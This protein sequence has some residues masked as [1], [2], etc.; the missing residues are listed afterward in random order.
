M[1]LVV[2]F[3]RVKADRVG[4]ALIRRRLAHAGRRIVRVSRYSPARYLSQQ[5][6]RGKNGAERDAVGDA[7]A[8]PT[9]PLILR[10]FERLRVAR[11]DRYALAREPLRASA[12]RILIA[13][14]PAVCVA[15]HRQSC[16]DPDDAFAPWYTRQ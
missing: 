12:Q 4:S 16:G 1:P 2:R 13:L 10:A 15:A 3:G 14:G 5:I 6:H 11:I 9:R 7:G 8:A